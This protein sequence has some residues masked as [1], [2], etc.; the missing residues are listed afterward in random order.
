MPQN[1]Q[2]HPPARKYTN[3]NAVDTLSNTHTHKRKHPH[4]DGPKRS[5]RVMSNLETEGKAQEMATGRGG[6]VTKERTHTHRGRERQ[7]WAVDE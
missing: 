2:E 4:Q 1:A 7:E 3:I 5:P 6:D